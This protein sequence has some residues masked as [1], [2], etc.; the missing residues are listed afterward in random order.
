MALLVLAV[1]IYGAFIEA[2]TPAGLYLVDQM[3]VELSNWGIPLLALVMILPFVTGL[4]TGMAVGYIGA[5]FPIVLS[6]IGNSPSIGEMLSMTVLAY[7]FG[8]IGFLLS[9]VHVCLVV[10]SEHF[11]TSVV[12]NMF[13]LLKPAFWVLAASIVLSIFWKIVL[14]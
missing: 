11:H 13:E 4:A 3:R 8:Y 14:A 2:E 5:S 1:R 9:P 10:T 6:L 7:G 12:K